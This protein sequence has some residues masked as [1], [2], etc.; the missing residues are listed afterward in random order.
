VGSI[1]ASARV[2]D[3][4]RIASDVEIGPY[5]VVG[6][7]V[8]LESGVRLLSH[9]NVSGVT[10]IGARTTIYPFASVGAAPQSIHYRGGA[11]RLEVGTDC[12]IRESVTLNTGTEDGGGVTV[13]GNQCLLMAG[14]H[15]AHDARVSDNVIVANG[16]AIAGHVEV[17]KFTVIGGHSGVHQFVRIGEG[18]MIAAHTLITQDVIP[19]GFALGHIGIL[20]GI[21]VTGMKR[22]GISADDI[23]TT[24]LAYKALFEGE[25]EFAARVDAVGA[26]FGD[27]LPVATIVG[28]IGSGTRALM[29]AKAHRRFAE[30]DDDE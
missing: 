3:G 27:C 25:G 14:V 26:Q 21:N 24:R 6:R 28:F 9:V 7:D 22:R 16:V 8:E 2:A 13:V 12:Q 11:T 19:F 17:G 20:G 30:T 10:R 1:D 29:K 23:R 15:V 18:A 4:A 5:C